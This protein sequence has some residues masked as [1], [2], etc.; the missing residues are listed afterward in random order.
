M[1]KRRGFEFSRLTKDI[2][3]RQAV[4]RGDIPQDANP[5]QYEFHHKTPITEARKRNL[6]SSLISSVA[7]V[8]VIRS[9]HHKD[10]HRD[11]T[12]EEMADDNIG[13]I[14]HQPSLFD[15]P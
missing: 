4:Q 14:P 9:D 3:W 2:A 1:T 11:Y 6:A 12:Y 7:N 8:L 13:D 5:S 15:E 10:L